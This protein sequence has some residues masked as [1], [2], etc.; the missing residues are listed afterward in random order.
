LGGN[1]GCFANVAGQYWGHRDEKCSGDGHGL[2]DEWSV[3]RDHLPVDLEAGLQNGIE[4]G[5]EARFSGGN[6]SATKVDRK[7]H[8]G[9][10]DVE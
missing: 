4:S 6:H 9:N 8:G 1:I 5:Q 2:S 7:L 3:L 10:N